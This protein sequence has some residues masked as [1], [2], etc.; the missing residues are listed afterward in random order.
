[1][2]RCN[3]ANHNVSSMNNFSNKLVF[4][5]DVVDIRL[6]SLE[7]ITT[8][9]LSLKYDGIQYRRLYVMFDRKL[10]EQYNLFCS[11]TNGYI[12]CHHVGNTKLLDTCPYY[13]SICIN[14]GHEI[15]FLESQ[16]IVLQFIL[17]ES[18]LPLN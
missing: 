8:P 2:Y 7:L 5:L 10:P 3:L 15:E 9:L 14:I 17:W 16:L 12:L 1:M 4:T 18:I 13:D 6:Y 11:F